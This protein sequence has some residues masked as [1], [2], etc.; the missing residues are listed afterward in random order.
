MQNLVLISKCLAFWTLCLIP[1]F[2][3]TTGSGNKSSSIGDKEK[4]AALVNTYVKEQGFSGTILIA[5]QGRPVFHQSYGLAY[6]ATPDTISNHYR[7]SIAS[8]TKMFT[9]IRV[10][11]LVETDSIDLQKAVIDYLPQYAKLLSNKV[12]VH[13]LLLHLSGLPNEKEK[14]YYSTLT[15]EEILAQTLSQKSKVK[16]G[17]FNYN[18]VD[19]LLL[20]LIIEVVSNEDWESNIRKHIIEPT[21]LS[22]TGFLAYGNYPDN[23]VYTYTYKGDKASQDPLFAIENFYAA[24]NMYATTNDLLA[25]D[26]ALYNNSL[27]NEDSRALL[28]KTLYKDNYVGYG[29]WNYNYPFV[30]EKPRVMERRGGILGANSVLVRL[31]DQNYTVIILSNDNRFNPDSFGDPNN[32]REILMRALYQ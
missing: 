10:L 29:V 3:F 19:Y 24:G 18:N 11:Q 25:L 30:E 32:L 31:I 6:Y 8:I 7:Y 14:A 27:L 1:L 20:G 9:S 28:M 4:L 5:K 22:N 26:Q 21:K 12:T 17:Q 15:P 23:F 13:H 16:F 2:A